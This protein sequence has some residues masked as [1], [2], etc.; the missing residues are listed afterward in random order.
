MPTTAAKPDAKSNGSGDKAPAATRGTGPKTPDLLKTLTPSKPKARRG[1]PPGKKTQTRTCA[2]IASDIEGKIKTM[3]P[4][5]ER[6]RK[7]EAEAQTLQA[8]A[9]ILRGPAK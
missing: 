2:Q 6:L 3:Q 1:R 4:D 5:I 8:A 7:L 9:D